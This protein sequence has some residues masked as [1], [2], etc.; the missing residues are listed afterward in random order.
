[1]S[2]EKCD[3]EFDLVIEEE[4][5]VRQTI[6]TDRHTP[7]VN[8]M[9]KKDESPIPRKPSL[10]RGM[11]RHY[12]G[13]LYHVDEVVLHSETGEWMVLYQS[14]DSGAYYVRPYGLFVGMA[15]NEHGFLVTRF[16]CIE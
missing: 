11:Y 2:A 5:S 8:E 7:D 4:N 16:A 13:G 15:Q 12:K 6:L 14:F 10:R 1:M 9:P 3:E